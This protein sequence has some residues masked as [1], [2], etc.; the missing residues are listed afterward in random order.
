MG[1][2]DFRATQASGGIEGS[3]SGGGGGGFDEAVCGAGAGGRY[4]GDGSSDTGGAEGAGAE[5]LLKSL[6]DSEEL[7][8]RNMRRAGGG[9]RLRA[10]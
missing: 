10:D 9:A 8:L 7:S 5:P 4:S 6:E 2:G 1:P 3:R